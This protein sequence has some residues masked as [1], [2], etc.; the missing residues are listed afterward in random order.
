MT[1]DMKRRFVKGVNELRGRVAEKR[2][3]VPLSNR[4]FN[5]EDLA[6]SKP[7]T[8]F[9][10]RLICRKYLRTFDFLELLPIR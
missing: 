9:H 8:S 7:L 3:V 4:V 10:F 6:A 2:L 1:P 5:S